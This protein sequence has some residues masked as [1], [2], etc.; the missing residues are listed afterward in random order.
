ME[1]SN[2]ESNQTALSG[3]EEEASF[4]SRCFQ[5]LVTNLS[6]GLSLFSGASLTMSGFYKE[7]IGN[8]ELDSGTVEYK[9]RQVGLIGLV[10]AVYSI[11]GYCMC[12]SRK[13]YTRV[14]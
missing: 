8:E 7:Q 3:S 14:S 11:V 13:L 10:I 9:S 12:C 6:F 5:K 4:S 2:V 1:S